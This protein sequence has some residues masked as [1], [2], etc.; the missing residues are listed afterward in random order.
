[1]E[2]KEQEKKKLQTTLQN[3]ETNLL[4]T[5]NIYQQLLGQKGLLEG[6]IKDLDTPEKKE[7][8]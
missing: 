5:Q 2:N 4:R 8:V 3:V 7:G 6:M 1:M